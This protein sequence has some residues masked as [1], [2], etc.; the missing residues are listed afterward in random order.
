MREAERMTLPYS[1]LWLGSRGGFVKKQEWE[2]DEWSGSAS[3]ALQKRC[4]KDE[5]FG[6]TGYPIPIALALMSSDCL[7]LFSQRYTAFFKIL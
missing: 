7:A 3:T 2:C 1:C 4:E 5:H 6:L